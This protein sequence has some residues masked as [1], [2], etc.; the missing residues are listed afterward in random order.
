LIN[1]LTGGSG[2][3]SN[4]LIAVLIFGTAGGLYAVMLSCLAIDKL[5][6][7]FYDNYASKRI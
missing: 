1:V 6:R 4:Q 3:S 2:M 7:Y 5:Y